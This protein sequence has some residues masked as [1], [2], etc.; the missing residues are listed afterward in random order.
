MDANHLGKIRYSDSVIADS[1]I[2]FFVEYNG[3]VLVERSDC[4]S[5]GRVG[6]IWTSSPQLW[7]NLCW[8]DFF[9]SPFKGN[10]LKLIIDV[11]TFETETL[12]NYVSWIEFL[13]D[14]VAEEI[15]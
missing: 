7:M 13:M 8:K 5:R 3:L 2:R 10:E 6:D 9:H 11:W 12:V 4:V 15:K 14:S 1:T